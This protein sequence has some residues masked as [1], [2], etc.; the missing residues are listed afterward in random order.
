MLNLIYITMI[1]AA[2]AVMPITTTSI[3][4]RWTESYC[5]DEYLEFTNDGEFKTYVTKSG[6]LTLIDK[7]IWWIDQGRVIIGLTKT[8]PTIAIA[9]DLV[10]DTNLVGAYATFS[11]DVSLLRLKKCL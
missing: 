6:E 10:T 1:K 8:L 11:G 9:A 4:G 3:T 5:S 7:Q 2:S